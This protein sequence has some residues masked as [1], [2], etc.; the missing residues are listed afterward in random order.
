LA[1]NEVIMKYHFAIL[2][3]DAD[4]FIVGQYAAT[5]LA[6]FWRRDGHTVTYIFGVKKFVPADLLLVHVDLSVV[7]D[8][9]LTFARQYPIVLNGK[10]KDIRK[11]TFSQYILKQDD[12][13][14]GPVLIKSN[15]NYVGI[16]E[17]LRLN[18]SRSG[19]F[20]AGFSFSKSIRTLL[21][22]VQYR[23]FKERSDYLIFDNLSKVPPELFKRQDIIVQRFC[24]EYEN[25]FYHVRSY[26]FMGD[27]Y[28]CE[29]ASSRQKIVKD[30]TIIKRKTVDVHP[31]IE[32]IR[33][34]L[35]FDYGKFDYVIHEGAPVLLDINKTVGSAR[36]VTPEIDAWR[37][38]WA[39]GIYS[40]IR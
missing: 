32:K 26:L 11:S 17:A 25:G 37:K 1:G 5:A 40:Y 14:S 30:V 3:H 22:V 19:D 10:I 39:Q 9:Y 38:H 15:F 7:P 34:E 21:K 13:Y 4:R 35:K 24:P 31:E 27:H 23:F 33:Y 6:E 8:E 18:R 28:I 2:F 20:P 16:P 12:D 29:H 36:K